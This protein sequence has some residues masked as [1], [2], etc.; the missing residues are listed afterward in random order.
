M[1]VRGPSGRFVASLDQAGL[2]AEAAELRSRGLPLREVA[3][4]QGVSITTAWERVQRALD[5]VRREGGEQAQAL[6]LEKLDRL[7]RRLTEALERR[8]VVISQGHVVTLDGVPVP[9][10]DPAVRAAAGLLRVSESR[11]KLLGLDAPVAQVL[12][13]ERRND[14][15]STAVSD[16]LLAAVDALQLAPEM[17]QF[18]LQTAGW[19]LGGRQ[20]PPPERPVIRASLPPGVG[21]EPYVVPPP[22]PPAPVQETLPPR[23]GDWA[24]LSREQRAA[25]ALTAEQ[26]AEI[27]ALLG[28]DD[29]A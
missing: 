16:A 24:E 29:E 7:E 6:E 10:D 26:I 8:H 25:G 14:E 19:A 23:G 22:Q 20:G 28:D 13:L 3:E 1:N 5:A 15:E 27:D 11:R 2:D 17:R 12:Q 9:D 4:R 18:A 21:A